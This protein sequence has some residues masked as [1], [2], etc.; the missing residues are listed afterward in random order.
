MKCPEC[1][2]NLPNNP[3]VIGFH[4]EMNHN[5]PR[6]IILTVLERMGYD[7]TLYGLGNLPTFT[8]PKRSTDLLEALLRKELER[9]KKDGG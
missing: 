5:A 2:R 4:F 8:I 6:S 3:C 9:R 1:K 7:I